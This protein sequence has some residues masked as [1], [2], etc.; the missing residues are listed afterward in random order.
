MFLRNNIVKVTESQKQKNKKKHKILHRTNFIYR[1]K[2]KITNISGLFAHFQEVCSICFAR[3][4]EAGQFRLWLQVTMDNICDFRGTSEKIHLMSDEFVS[5]C[6]RRRKLFFSVLFC[7]FLKAFFTNCPITDTY[8]LELGRM[9]SLCKEQSQWC[10]FNS[11]HL[12]I[13]VS[14]C[15]CFLKK[16]REANVRLGNSSM[17]TQDNM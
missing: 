5:F 9:P 16:Q 14:L 15:F 4:M 11:M 6:N 13:C 3:I 7:I 10:V 12:D 8:L 17:Y 1:R 2:K